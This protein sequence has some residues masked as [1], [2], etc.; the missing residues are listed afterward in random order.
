MDTL[1]REPREVSTLYAPG[2]KLDQRVGGKH[3]RIR[4]SGPTGRGLTF[5]YAYLGHQ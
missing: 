1:G 4:S 3:P 2:P 5:N